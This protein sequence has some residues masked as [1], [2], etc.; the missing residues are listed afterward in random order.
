ML[1]EKEFARDVQQFTNRTTEVGKNEKKAKIN[2]G[3]G[4]D[5][6]VYCC[7]AFF[8]GTGWCRGP[9]TAIQRHR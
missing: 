6:G 2:D 3:A 5:H 1:I 4:D 7:G 9:L 8:A